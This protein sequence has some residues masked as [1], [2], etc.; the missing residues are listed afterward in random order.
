MLVTSFVFYIFALIIHHDMIKMLRLLSFLIML[1]LTILCVGCDPEGTSQMNLLGDLLNSDAGPTLSAEQLL[2]S[3][4]SFNQ[5]KKGFSIHFPVTGENT[6]PKD[7]GIYVNP[8]T[9]SNIRFV[10][11]PDDS[12]Y[13]MGTATIVQQTA[14]ELSFGRS[15]L[16]SVLTLH[17]QSRGKGIY[18]LYSTSLN[19]DSITRRIWS[20]VLFYVYP[21][22]DS[23][24]TTRGSESTTHIFRFQ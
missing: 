11:T 4:E 19:S 23:I 6:S 13:S 22:G 5:R 10:L 1:S 21:K 9:G 3:I 7:N 24:M 17:V 18:A 16:D 15:S 14:G 12:L 20:R 2:D 8:K